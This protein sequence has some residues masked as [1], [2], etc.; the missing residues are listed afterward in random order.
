MGPAPRRLGHPKLRRRGY[1]Y[2]IE[3][4][5]DPARCAYSTPSTA[6]PV[7]T[8][9]AARTEPAI[10]WTGTPS[11]K[12]DARSGSVPPVQHQRHLANTADD[13]APV[14]TLTYDT[15]SATLGDFSGTSAPSN[16]GDATPRSAPPIRPTT[17]GADD[18]QCPPGR[19]LSPQRQH[20]ARWR[21]HEC[22]R[23]EP[24]LDLVVVGRLVAGLRQRSD[25]RLHH[26]DGGLQAF[27]FSQ[28][29]SV[30]DGKQMVIELFDPGEVSGNGFLRFQNPDGNVYNYATFDWV[31]DDGRSGNNVTQIQTSVNG[32]AQFNNRLLTITVDL[33]TTYG[34]T[35]LNPP[36]DI[37]PEGLVAVEYN[38]TGE[39][40]PPLG[41]EHPGG[42]GQPRPAQD[43]IFRG[44]RPSGIRRR[45]VVGRQ[46]LGTTPRC[47]GG[48]AE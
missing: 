4:P 27:Y 23:R 31:S 42:N 24:L 33:P 1:D 36:G 5:G 18:R 46:A 29:E 48:K 3:L 47:R 45:S 43:A 7:R 9:P 44:S 13:G 32:A 15:G 20:V 17:V 14:G 40:T 19:H 34:S 30:H 8:R 25:G 26:L 28:I 12:V 2:I 41:S 38:V 39:T 21:Q 16:Q 37:T 22:R 6:R 10:T 11:G 35:G